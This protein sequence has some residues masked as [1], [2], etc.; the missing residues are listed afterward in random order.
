MK[1]GAWVLSGQVFCPDPAISPA[2]FTFGV[3][4]LH[5]HLV[6]SHGAH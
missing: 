5:N 4:L 1:K 2:S 3:L 6:F